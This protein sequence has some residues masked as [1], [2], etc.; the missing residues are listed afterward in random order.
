M[1]DLKEPPAIIP[2][3]LTEAGLGTCFRQRKEVL[4]GSFDCNVGY[5]L[6]SD[7]PYFGEGLWDDQP[8]QL[9]DIPQTDELPDPERVNAPTVPV[10][11]GKPVSVPRSYTA[12]PIKSSR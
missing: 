1:A 5:Q 3:S 8:L 12:N 2:K 6:I 11:L 4:Q 10:G 7:I 9:H